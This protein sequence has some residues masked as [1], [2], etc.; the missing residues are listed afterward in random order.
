MRGN[1]LIKILEALEDGAMN[2]INFFEAVLVSGY[3][4]SIG[5]IDYEHKKLQKARSLD[6]VK[7]EDTAQKIKRLSIFLS[8]IKR[9]G[10]LE[11]A[12]DNTNKQFKITQKGK[13]KLLQ[14][15]NNLPE[16]HY[17][18]KIGGN[19]VIISFDIPERFRNK[20]NWF[21]DVIRNLGF[22]MIHQSVWLGKTKIPKE[23]VEN[24]G[25][26]DILAYVQI[27]EISKSGTLKKIG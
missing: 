24:M 14:L 12:G 3:G 13:S 17:E 26:L 7:N 21:R 10:L 22:E 1:I 5:K 16:K 25:K 20:R 4:A 2:Q 15:K 19:V 27:F 18:K 8:K 9:D 11:E 23:L 6:K